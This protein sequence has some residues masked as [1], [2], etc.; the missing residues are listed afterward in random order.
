MPSDLAI[1]LVRADAA[2]AARS[3]AR[4]TERFAAGEARLRDRLAGAFGRR[5]ARRA[6]ARYWRHEHPGHQH[7]P[8][9]ARAGAH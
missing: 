1:H 3:G 6:R 7:A 9:R 4:R 2:D 5:R 8:D